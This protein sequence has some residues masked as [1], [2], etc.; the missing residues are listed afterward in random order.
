MLHSRFCQ[1]F[2]DRLRFWKHFMFLGSWLRCVSFSRNLFSGFRLLLPKAARRSPTPA[3]S[4]ASSF[5]SG[6]AGVLSLALRCGQACASQQL[7][8]HNLCWEHRIL[9]NIWWSQGLGLHIHNFFKR[10]KADAAWD[11]G[12]WDS[13]AN[14]NTTPPSL[15]SPG[16]RGWTQ[17]WWPK[18]QGTAT[19][20]GEPTQVKHYISQQ[21]GKHTNH[22][23]TATFTSK[24]TQAHESPKFRTSNTQYKHHMFMRPLLKAEFAQIQYVFPLR[25]SKWYDILG[26]ELHMESLAFAM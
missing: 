7:L 2:S 21:K 23:G 15:S 26:K 18:H 8:C 24:I 9:C 6:A 10:S 25:F 13:F 4:S 11:Y 19:F 22:Q 16:R 5:V 20:K 14:P 1:R 17:A 3:A 12:S